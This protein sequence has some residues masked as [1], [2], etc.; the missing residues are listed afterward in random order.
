MGQLSH[1]HIL[2]PGTP[3]PS[4]TEMALLCHPVKVQG[5]FSWGSPMPGQ[6]NG[7]TLLVQVWVNHPQNCEPGREAP[8]SHLSCGD[9]GGG[10][11]SSFHPSIPG[12][13]GRVGLGILRWER[14]SWP[15]P[16]GTLR[17]I[18]FVFSLGAYIW[19][20]DTICVYLKLPSWT[21]HFILK[22]SVYLLTC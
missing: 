21:A 16:A 4:L 19:N 3:I 15:P 5:L 22:F 1:V 7:A 9:M 11:K 18:F 20:N 6:H 17:N 13:G 12:A 14:C 10:K 8:I 2:E